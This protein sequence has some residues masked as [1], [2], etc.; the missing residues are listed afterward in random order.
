MS[1]CAR[2]WADQCDLHAC[3]RSREGGYNGSEGLRYVYFPC[4]RRLAAPVDDAVDIKMAYKV[5]I[6]RQVIFT[7]V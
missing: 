3:T 7:L 6:V 2:Y 4:L 1:H 5:N